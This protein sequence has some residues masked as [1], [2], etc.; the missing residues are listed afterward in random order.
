MQQ[1]GSLRRIRSTKKKAGSAYRKAELAL[2]KDYLAKPNHP[3]TRA[4]LTLI[5]R[6]TLD[7]LQAELARRTLLGLL[8][9]AYRAV[10]IALL[11]RFGPKPPMEA[12]HA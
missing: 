11:A 4:E 2:G 10:R 9:R 5:T 7:E 3:V 1:M 8:D 6:R 12:A